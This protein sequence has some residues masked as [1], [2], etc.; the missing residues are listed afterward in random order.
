MQYERGSLLE[1]GGSITYDETEERV[2]FLVR[3]EA[4]GT[5][6]DAFEVI[7]LYLKVQYIPPSLLSWFV[8][9]LHLQGVE[10]R[11]D[12]ITQQCTQREIDRPFRP[13]GVPPNATSYGQLY[14]GTSGDPE[15]GLLVDIFGGEFGEGN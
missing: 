6:F 5:L 7:E 3:E 8:S 4:N 13:I 15:A 2:R 14:I 12:Y 10:Y 11:Y 9:V 1:E